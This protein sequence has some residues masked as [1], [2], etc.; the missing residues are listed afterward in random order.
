[1]RLVF[2]RGPYRGDVKNNI[3]HAKL[4]ASR[5]IALG[6]SVI[7]PHLNTAYMD[8]EFED[9]VFL[10]M[11]LEML[12]RCDAIYMLHNWHKSVGSCGEYRLAKELGLEI[13]YE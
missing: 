3:L 12:R 4:A 7:I 11:Y 5:L 6:Y 13:M 8:D 10:D 1:M 2:V 9:R